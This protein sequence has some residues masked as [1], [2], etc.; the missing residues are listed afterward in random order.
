MKT[1]MN[2]LENSMV[3]VTVNANKDAWKK[4]QEDELKKAAENVEIDGFRKGNAPLNKV[5]QHVN[6][7]DVLSSAADTLLNDMFRKA[8]EDHDL[9]PVA[10]PELNVSKMDEEE[11]EVIFNIAIKP[12]FEVANYKGL[13]AEKETAV[14]EDSEIEQQLEALRAQQVTLE[15][16]EKAVENG[17]TAVIDFEG[18][19]D[20]VA[21]EGGKAESFPLEIG[22]GQFIPGFEEQ[23]VGTKAG[24][25]LDVEVTFP[26]EYQ[27]ED[28]AGQPVVFKVTVHEV[29]QKIEAELNDE[30]AASIG[31]ENVNTMAE[32]KEDMSKQMLAQKQN[33]VEMKY[34]N[35]LMKQVADATEIAVPELMIKGEVDA[36]YQQF[37]QNLQ[38]QGLNEEMF[39]Q[40]TNQKPEDLREQMEA[41]AVDKIKF[42]LIL[43]KI[44]ELEG[45]TV[46]PSELDSEYAKMAEMY[47]MEVEQIKQMI[48]DTAGLE[49][50]LKMQKTADLVKEN[51]K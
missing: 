42:T 34:T 2:E 47:N 39:L 35:A 48:P 27:Q 29:K 9:W 19:K 12:E 18:F 38:Q 36:L 28:L 17:D 10:N 3:E 15:V 14:V 40:M 46:D 6:Q 51:A 50:E 26:E 22:S 21:F 30:F 33:E 7:F 11:L 31:V 44:A 24:D 8:I 4:A 32:L 5:K 41:D 16:V 1:K 13:S 37:M 49:F 20:G 23:L 45:I 43:E 25:V